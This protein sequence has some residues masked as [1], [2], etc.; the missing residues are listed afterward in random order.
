MWRVMGAALVGVVP[1]V[2][3]LPADDADRVYRL[4]PDQVDVDRVA[5]SPAIDT[6]PGLDIVDGLITDQDPPPAVDLTAIR[7]SG[8][9]P[10]AF[11][12]LD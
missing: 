6:I 4:I 9:P 7:P 10:D 1:L 3:C 5:P 12:S 8:L 2:G 11:P